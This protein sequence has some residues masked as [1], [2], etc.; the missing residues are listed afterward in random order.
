MGVN[1]G[2]C[3]VRLVATGRSIGYYHFTMSKHRSACWRLIVLAAVLGIGGCMTYGPTRENTA[4]LRHIKSPRVHSTPTHAA[5]LIAELRAPA[6][7]RNAYTPAEQI[8]ANA[9]HELQQGN[10]WDAA[11]LLSLASYR[12]HQQA[13]LAGEIGKE[14]LYRIHPSQHQEFIEMVGGEMRL[15]N[16]QDF[17][18]EL[19]LLR[20][21]LFGTAAASERRARYIEQLARGGREDDAFGQKLS[22]F[23]T[24]VSNRHES[25]YHSE[26]ARAFQDRLLADNQRAGPDGF[27][28]YYL[29]ATPLDTF[30]LAALHETRS[31]FH[32]VLVRNLAPRMQVL[33]ESVLASLKGGS[34]YARSN[35]AIALGLASQPENVPILLDRLNAE[36]DPRVVDSLRFALVRHERDDFLAPLLERTSRA[37]G[38]EREHVLTLLQ[39]LP[40]QT[41]A[42]LQESAFI[43]IAKQRDASAIARGMA[44]VVVGDIASQRALAQKAVRA[45]LELV[46]DSEEV[47]AASA[48]MA[49][50]QLK[51]S[52]AE[53]KSFYREY[54]AARPSLLTR[55]A[56]VA[57]LG[58]LE[59]LDRAYSDGLT[60][61]NDEAG[62]SDI[63]TAAIQATASIAGAASRQLLERW[64]VGAANDSS[65][66]WLLAVMLASRTDADETRLTG[67][68]N[69]TRSTRLMLLLALDSK[70]LVEAMNRALPRLPI[71]DIAQLVMMS[72]ILER[73]SLRATMWRLA[74]YDN[75]RFYP[76]DAMVRRLAISALVRIALRQRVQQPIEK[77][78]QLAPGQVEL[79]DAHRGA[80]P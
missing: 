19:D 80:T 53:C 39:W 27:A 63:Q 68:K 75:F 51:L 56:E 4:W 73:N 28:F 79:S 35:V 32:T 24:R 49:I 60:E 78:G 13:V 42:T 7:D 59:F 46:G 43:A 66:R 45:L 62:G 25:L 69:L 40:A 3:L 52:A 33:R 6:L 50:K 65:V 17:D 29:A 70:E 10:E 67:L 14:Q 41:K 64:L 74:S 21:H 5:R 55:L 44:I 77:P 36:T 31:A 1:T 61:Q 37:R 57:S 23:Q 26:L 22:D 20:D 9:V 30:R 11:L 18:R 38:Q 47:V 72:A 76:A 16:D 58:D 12:Y 8:A 54:R 2:A 71:S 48:E 34:T 15:F